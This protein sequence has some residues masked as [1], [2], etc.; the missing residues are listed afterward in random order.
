MTKQTKLIM[1]GLGIFLFA[2]NAFAIYNLLS[3]G[4]YPLLVIGSMISILAIVILML[5][6]FFPELP[7]FRKIEAKLFYTS[8][9]K[10]A[11]GLAF[12]GAVLA[13]IIGLIYLFV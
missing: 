13:L 9:S 5:D 8:I 1:L 12:T 3:E 7:L 2:Y 6:A 10:I 4:K 11:S